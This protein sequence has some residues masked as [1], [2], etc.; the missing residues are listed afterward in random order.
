MCFIFFLKSATRNFR[1]MI[2]LHI[3]VMYAIVLT[4][5]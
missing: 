1:A 3:Q 4:T 2:C 5:Q